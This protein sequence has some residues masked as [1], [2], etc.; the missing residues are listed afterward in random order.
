MKIAMRLFDAA[1]SD[2][3]TC[4]TLFPVQ[5]ALRVF[6]VFV[7]FTNGFVWFGIDRSGTGVRGRLG[8]M[9][10]CLRVDILPDDRHFAFSHMM[11]N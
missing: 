8:G 3:R 9:R 10:Q 4:G 5:K 6:N 2:A 7:D 1:H 11:V